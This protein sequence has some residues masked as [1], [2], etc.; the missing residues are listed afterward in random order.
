MGDPARISILLDEPHARPPAPAGEEA[1][2]PLEL[3]AGERIFG[4]VDVLPLEDV[5]FSSFRIGLFWHTEGKGNPVTGSGRV[6]PLS[7]EGVWKSGERVRFNFSLHAPWGPVSY[8][9]RILKVVWSLEARLD[10]SMLVPDFHEGIPVH[11]RA[12]PDAEGVDLGPKPQKKEE[13]EAV[14]RGLGGVWSTLAVLLLVG[15][16]VFGAS[17]GWEMERAERFFLML[18]LAGGFLL[19]LMGIWGRLG[20][21]KLGEP[22]IQLSTTELRLGEAIRFSLAMRP[23]RRTELRSLDAI[24]EC[25]ERVV[26]GH[27]QYRSHHRKVVFER[28]ISLAEDLLV[29]PHRGFRRKGVLTLPE[30]AP[31]SFGAPDNQVV[32]WLRF[33]GD[34]V[35]WPDWN[36]PF[37]LTVRP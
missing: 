6:I 28:R 37:L 26:H 3:R 17:H 34:I 4:T 24:L 21:G 27:G 2:P 1:A 12:D 18:M 25:E 15:G 36:E 33:Q 10:R 5:E 35:G 8:A 29:E 30:D 23:E 7:D 31:P 9:G 19:M 11:L 16:V 13:L 32:W 14:K 20:R 22:A